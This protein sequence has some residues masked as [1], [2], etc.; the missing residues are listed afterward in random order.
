MTQSS[1][2]NS[3]EIHNFCISLKITIM[4]VS[5]SSLFYGEGT[6]MQEEEYHQGNKRLKD[7]EEKRERMEQELRKYNLENTKKPKS[8]S[9]LRKVFDVIAV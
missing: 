9:Y 7:K 6:V 1:R 8:S 2:Q 3:L 5:M 4:F